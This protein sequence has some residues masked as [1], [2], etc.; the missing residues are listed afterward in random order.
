M[1]ESIHILAGKRDRFNEKLKQKLDNL[2]PTAKLNT[3]LLILLFYGVMTLILFVN[4]IR[5]DSKIVK[6]KHIEPV[7]IIDAPIKHSQ[8]N[9]SLFTDKNSK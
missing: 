7:S 1:K 8:K 6:I 9:D 4:A 3:I 2:S 5:S